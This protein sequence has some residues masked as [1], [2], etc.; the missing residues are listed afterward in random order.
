MRE[1]APTQIGR[2]TM[3][4]I[5]VI[6]GTG[7]IGTYLVPALVDQ[8][9]DVV[10]VSRGLAKSYIHNTA[11]DRVEQ[12]TVDR[13]EEEKAGTFVERI[14]GLKPDIVIDL[15]SFNLASTRPLVEALRGKIE[16]FLHCSTLWVYGH[17]AAVPAG[18][19]EPLNPFGEYGTHVILKAIRS[20]F[21]VS[22]R[23]KTGKGAFRPIVCERHRPSNQIVFTI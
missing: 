20:P 14:V 4:R 21:I 8:G 5:I 22:Q 6:G 3:S 9:H 13:Q 17:T 12:V 16:H 1:R 19:D 7:H 18:E 15:I 2:M 23:N 11:W 10:S